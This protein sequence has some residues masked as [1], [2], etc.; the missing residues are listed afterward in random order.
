MVATL[1]CK[2]PGPLLVNVPAP[3]IPTVET[4]KVP[5]MS[6]MSAVPELLTTMPPVTVVVPV[7]DCSKVGLLAPLKVMDSAMVVPPGV[8]SSKVAP[9]L[10]ALLMTMPP[11]LLP[12]LAAVVTMSRPP[13]TVVAPS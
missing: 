5:L 7:V 12:R 3:E 13:L 6:A 4:A 2:V 10:A 1:S 9:A 8:A 11:L